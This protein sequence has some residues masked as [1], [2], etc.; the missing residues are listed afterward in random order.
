MEYSRLSVLT[1]C[2]GFLGWP[3]LQ[4]EDVPGPAAGEPVWET[5]ACPSYEQCHGHHRTARGFRTGRG[6]RYSG[7][8][9]GEGTLKD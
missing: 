7:V 6:Y 1:L 4:W 5:P 2:L 3:A 9:G 8:G